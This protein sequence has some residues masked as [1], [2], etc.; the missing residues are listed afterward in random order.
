[1]T[2]M[3]SG[4]GLQPLEN[5]DSCVMVALTGILIWLGSRLRGNADIE[6][7]RVSVENLRSNFSSQQA[8]LDIEPRFF[9][10]CVGN[11]YNRI[12]ID[13]GLQ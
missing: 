4:A 1:M 10:Y 3:A 6:L 8:V 2:D 13:L 5:A 12:L 11:I 9:N 7:I